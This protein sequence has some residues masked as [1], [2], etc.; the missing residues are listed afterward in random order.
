[1]S[2]HK[3]VHWAVVAATICLLAAPRAS[4]SCDGVTLDSLVKR[5][6]D[7]TLNATQARYL[8]HFDPGLEQSQVGVS[9]LAGWIRSARSAAAKCLEPGPA[10]IIATKA[11]SIRVLID[12]LR[13]AEELGE[14]P[15]L[16]GTDSFAPDS[17]SIS[18][19]PPNDD[20]LQATP[21]SLGSIAGSTV[22]AEND[23]QATCG[24]SFDSGDIWFKYTPTASGA[25]SFDTKGS[26]FDTVVSV[27]RDCPGTT[28]NEIVCSDDVLGTAAAGAVFLSAGREYWFRVAG[29]NGAQGN[30]LLTL[31]EGGVIG[32]NV[33]AVGGV[34]WTPGGQVRLTNEDGFSVSSGSI[35]SD[36]SYLIAGLSPGNL[37]ARTQYTQLVN[38]IF[39]DVVCTY[40]GCPIEEA[41]PIL[42]GADTFS[43]VDFQLD[44]GGRVSGQV[45]DSTTLLPVVGAQL[46]LTGLDSFSSVYAYSDKNGEFEF[47]GRPPGRY[48]LFVESNEHVDEY[49][50]GV[51]CEE[52]FPC[53][54]SG[55]TE[56]ILSS[57]TDHVAGLQ[58]TLE[59][60]ATISGTVTDETSG[61][62]IEGTFVCAS[63][64]GY[65]T[66]DY[67]NAGGEYTIGVPPGTYNVS[68]SSNSHYWEAYD[69]YL[70]E[71]GF[72]GTNATDIVVELVNL[73]G[74]DAALT[75]LPSVRGHVNSPAAWNRVSATDGARF[76]ETSVNADGSYELSLPNPG[77]YFVYASGQNVLT[78]V[79]DDVLCLQGPSNCS[80]AGATPIVVA[81]STVVEDIDF[82]LMAG[83]SI[84]G[85][86]L[87]PSGERTSA[88]VELYREGVL[89]QT[90]YVCSSCAYSIDNLAPGTYTLRARS[91]DYEDQL[92]QGIPCQLDG[93]DPA[94]GTPVTVGLGE[95]VLGVDFQLAELAVISGTVLD[96]SGQPVS[97]GVRAYNPTTRQTTYETIEPSGAY[98]IGSLDAGS[99]LIH[100]AVDYNSPLLNEAWDDVLCG[101]SCSDTEGSLIT[102]QHQEQVADIDFILPFESKIDVQLFSSSDGE[103]V[104]GQL[105]L[106]DSE[107]R[108][109]ATEWGS[110]VEFLRLRPG[111]YYLR[112]DYAPGYALALWDGVFCPPFSDCDPTTGTPI[113]LGEEEGAELSMEVFPLGRVSGTVSDTSSNLLSFARVRLYAESDSEYS[114]DFTNQDGMFLFEDLQPGI[115]YAVTA[116]NHAYIDESYDDIPCLVA[117]PA[118]CDHTK[119]APIQVLPDAETTG[120]DFA[121]RRRTGLAYGMMMRLGGDPLPRTLVDLWDEVGDHVTTMLTD[122]DGVFEL[123]GLP[124]GVYYLSTDVAEDLVN[125]V[126][127]NVYCFDGSAF[128][129]ACDPLQGSPISLP[130]QGPEDINVIFELEEAGDIENP[131]IFSDSFESGDATAWGSTP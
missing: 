18:G 100:T 121:L 105:E 96:S 104:N 78:E 25:L 113:V 58:I 45:T 109:I 86:V 83:G 7:I 47:R 49:Y 125:E 128:S 5:L 66:C 73:T 16:P 64:S 116:S 46:E 11:D 22:G 131:S 56:I 17:L 88:N 119:G 115:Y 20:C 80:T 28:S 107:G 3:T 118:G 26:D 71:A 6:A 10:G 120:I 95:Q 127:D 102:L 87:N 110:D 101:E 94:T 79:W 108:R 33:A 59:Q 44:P 99:Y 31:G 29:Y 9:E 68:F 42:V 34:E 61:L 37:L 19:A 65:S 114:Q 41:T 67:T 72:D 54:S 39:E 81:M 122:D 52:F 91:S 2:K 85:Q 130:N 36:G 92:F 124:S 40:D 24:A 82:E 53:D 35:E 77:S 15:P 129:G 21:I 112:L 103:P 97:G 12:D 74:F 8:A 50:D 117:P 32:G 60:M 30:S 76:V 62:P 106:Y 57:N 93:C 4:A 111:T 63:P 14:A 51:L 13:R 43:T 126:F 75:P 123:T 27:H 55:R 38:E 98:S 89:Q 48:S 84:Q 1:M 90:S 69:N 70:D 23:G